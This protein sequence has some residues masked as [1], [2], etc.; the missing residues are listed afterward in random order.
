MA[1][2]VYVDGA[3]YSGQCAWAFVVVD[4]GTKIS[5]YARRMDDMP[6]DLASQQNVAA[7]M[8]AAMM[9]AAW[10]KENGVEVEICYDYEGVEKW[11]TEQWSAG[12]KYT[13]MY[14]DYMNDHPYVV[15]Y[16]HIKAHSGHKWNERVDQLAESAARSAST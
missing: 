1:T 9:G 4:G 3:F 14:R 11:A 5:E 15:K 12:N 8:K 13:R 16:R 7:E 6:E 10:A 2:Q